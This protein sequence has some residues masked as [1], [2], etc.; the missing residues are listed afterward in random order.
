MLYGDGVRASHADVTLD[1][2]KQIYLKHK[3]AG[4]PDTFHRAA[5]RTTKYLSEAIG[6]KTI[7]KIQRTAAMYTH[8][9]IIIV[10][11][12]PIDPSAKYFQQLFGDYYDQRGAEE[13]TKL[14]LELTSIVSGLGCDFVDASEFG[15]TGDD[16][17]HWTKATHRELAQR[18]AE[19]I[20]G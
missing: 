4:R 20:Q 2:A 19:I 18:L 13:S 3:G 8:P 14:N 5:E 11:P 9:K 10:S 12:P 16:G 17:I 15:V 7:G 6:A 1:Q